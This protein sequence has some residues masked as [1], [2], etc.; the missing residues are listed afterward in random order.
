MAFVF[1][2]LLIAVLEMKTV[3]NNPPSNDTAH[4]ISEEPDGCTAPL[5]EK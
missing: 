5:E 4:E 3:N 1:T 2:F